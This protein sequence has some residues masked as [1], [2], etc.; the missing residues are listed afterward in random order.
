MLSSSLA[1]D[2]ESALLHDLLG[3]AYGMQGKYKQAIRVFKKALDIDPSFHRARKNLANACIGAM[4]YDEAKKHF[5]NLAKKQPGNASLFQGFINACLL[6]GSYGEAARQAKTRVST[7]PDEPRYHLMYGSTLIRQ[8]KYQ[9]AARF[10]ADYLETFKKNALFKDEIEDFLSLRTKAAEHT[11]KKNQ[12]L[13]GGKNNKLNLILI[14]IDTTRS[15][16]IACYGNEKI[17]T[18]VIDSL[19]HNGVLFKNAFSQAPITLPSHAS[20][21]TGTNPYAHGVRNNSTYRLANDKVT[22]AEI[23]KQHGYN[24][25]AFISSFILDSRFGLDQGYDLYHDDFESPRQAT[26]HL[27]VERRGDEVSRKAID[28]LKN[29]FNEPFS[30]WLHYYDPHATYD[31]PSPFRQAYP[32]RPYDGEIAYTDYC[33]GCVLDTIK[34]LGVSE[35]TIIVFAADHGESFGEHG[36]QTHGFFIYDATTHVPLV[37][38]SPVLKKQYR[39]THVENLVRTIDIFPTVLD[40]LTIACPDTI[41]G[42]TLMPIISG[43]EKPKHRTSYCEAMIPTDYNWSDLVSLRSLGWKYINAP[44]PELYNIAD[45]PGEIDNKYGAH[46]QKARSMKEKLD[47]LLTA[48]K[49]ST[50]DRVPLDQGTINRLQA[51]GY[52]HVGGDPGT[53]DTAGGSSP[54]KDLKDPKDMISVFKLFQKANSTAG[55]GDTDR[56]LS[57]MKQ[58]VSRDPANPRF[59]VA[60]GNIYLEQENY[61]KAK[62][63]FGRAAAQDPDDARNHFLLGLVYQKTGNSTEAIKKYDRAVTLN[64]G[65]FLS[66]YNL[67]LIHTQNAAFDRGETFF[68]KAL[69]I[70]PR[71]PASLNNL[72]YIYIKKDEDFKKGISLIE[73]AVSIAPDNVVFRDSLGWAYRNRGQKEKALDILQNAHEMEPENT[74]VLEHIACVLEDMNRYAEA[75]TWW[76]KLLTHQSDNRT[77]LEHIEDLRSKM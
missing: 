76:E 65:H 72:A 25:A 70:N 8:A 57:L 73:K 14:T 31:S 39:G 2:P 17:A 32:G 68:K 55:E 16:H 53:P 21:L 77:A 26:K 54:E 61:Q 1:Q 30:L 18:P 34:N 64:P 36:E 46:R 75:V 38:S 33:I 71:H 27:P 45:D 42:R 20:I 23:M 63:Q 24:T 50:A 62:K 9:D 7:Y 35:N 40:M 52:L 48:S 69:E 44:R 28:W 19:A 58:V 29:N 10:F 56:A 67:G 66:Y 3:S 49:D 47:S 41:D 6:Q 43:T 11:H 5:L 22:L 74:S 15:D 51:L 60:L 59:R 4:L 12:P 13:A 37:I